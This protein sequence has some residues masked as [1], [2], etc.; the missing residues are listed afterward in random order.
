MKEQTSRNLQTRAQKII[1]SLCVCVCV[2]V[3]AIAKFS[4][5]SVL[6]HTRVES[7]YLTAFHF[8]AGSSVYSEMLF[9]FIERS[10]YTLAQLR[11][12]S[13]HTTQNSYIHT[14]IFYLTSGHNVF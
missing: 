11:G 8:V 9:P 14:S 3:C 4:Q 13:H 2:C 6:S 1:N 12:C 10:L 5:L 7:F